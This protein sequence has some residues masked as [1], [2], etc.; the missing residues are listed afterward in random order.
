MLY[1][2]DL[3]K[4]RREGSDVPKVSSKLTLPVGQDSGST[5]LCLVCGYTGPLLPH[6]QF[7]SWE[8]T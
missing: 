6:F 2:Q 5:S 8:L 3:G 4:E 1:I 7:D